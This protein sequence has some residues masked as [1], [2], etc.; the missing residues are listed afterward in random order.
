MAICHR[1]GRIWIP[2]V[3]RQRRLLRRTCTKRQRQQVPALAR[4]CPSGSGLAWPVADTWQA[5]ERTSGSAL[6]LM[7]RWPELRFAHSTPA[8]YAWMEL[9]RPALFAEIQAASRAGR[10]EPI[11]G[12]WVETDRVLVST[13]S[14]WNQFAV[15]QDDSRR[16]FPEWAHELA[17]LPDSWFRGRFACGGG[18][19]RCALVL[20]PQAGLEC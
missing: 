8:L 19:H 2:A 7:R 6:A 15:G 13:A 9:H 14:L 1:V 18:S 20:H 4:P 12:P 11:N 17:W 16:C 3:L 5:A 10:W